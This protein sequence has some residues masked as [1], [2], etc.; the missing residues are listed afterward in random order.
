VSDLP[1]LVRLDDGLLDAHRAAHVAFQSALSSADPAVEVAVRHCSRRLLIEA[2][3]NLLVVFDDVERP[4]LLP[5]PRRFLGEL[6]LQRMAGAEVALR[7]IDSALMI[8]TMLD[9]RPAVHAATPL[10]LNALLAGPVSERETN[11]GLLRATVTSW[12][13]DANAFRHPPPE[14]VADLMSAATAVAA[15][16][17]V[18]AVERAG[19]LTFITMTLHPFVDGNGRTARALFL[20][21]AGTDLP[22]E[23]D[24]GVLDQWHLSRLAYVD[25]LQAGQRAEQY[26][27]D[28]VDPGPFVRYSVRSSIRGAEVGVAR[29]GLLSEAVDTVADLRDAIVLR[30]VVDRFATFDELLA[31]SQDDPTATMAH[32]DELVA[33]RLLEI[34]HAPP[35]A[36][37]V[38]VRGVVV[39]SAIADVVVQLRQARYDGG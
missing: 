32:I 17:S 11:P 13:P 30:T 24:W 1:A 12:K 25:A 19:W 36:P 22:G 2:L 27:G 7:H 3:A 28:A 8:R 34:R 15:D 14:D 6:A 35:G 31:D 10:V 23:I 38:G 16:E 9:G 26:A 5:P 4:I 33:R 21:V 39:G 37:V 18:P 29:V 20:A